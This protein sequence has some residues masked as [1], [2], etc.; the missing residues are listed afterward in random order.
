MQ[1][2]SFFNRYLNQPRLL[3]LKQKNCVQNSFEGVTTRNFA[4]FI[5]VMKDD[6][7]LPVLSTNMGYPL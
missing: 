5:D 4:F 1:E 2:S 3:F 6:Q 7:G